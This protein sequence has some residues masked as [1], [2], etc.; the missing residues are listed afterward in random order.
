MNA[1]ETKVNNV[2]N[3]IRPYLQNDGGD[4]EFVEIKDNVVYVRMVGACVGCG[5]IDM[6][7]RE[8]IETLIL[9]EVPTIIGVEQVD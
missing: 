9:E 8:T 1:I 6:T 4:C 2:L 7:L 5:S 3:R